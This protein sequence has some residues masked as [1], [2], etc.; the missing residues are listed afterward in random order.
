MLRDFLTETF[1]GCDLRALLARAFFTLS[2]FLLKKERFVE[3]A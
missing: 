3:N 1:R 2:F